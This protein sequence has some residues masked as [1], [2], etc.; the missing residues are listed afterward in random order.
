MDEQTVREFWQDNACGDAQVGGLQE[1][2]KGD[3]E[4]FFTDYDRFR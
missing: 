4:E 1:R 3:Y 2:F